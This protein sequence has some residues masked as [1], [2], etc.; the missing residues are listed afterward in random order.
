LIGWPLQASDRDDALET[1][2]ARIEGGLLPASTAG[3]VPAPPWNIHERMRHY[4]VPGVSIAVI[5][6]YTLEWV[7]SYGVLEAGGNAPVTDETLFQAASISKPVTAMGI[8][9][10]AQEGRLKLDGEAN[11]YLSMWRIPENQFTVQQKV[12]PGHLLTHTAGM[13][14]W[15]Y[16]GYFFDQPLPTLTQ[17]LDGQRPPANSA[18]IRV[19]RV[20]GT[21]FVYSNG[22][23]LV[24]QQMAMDVTGMPFDT[25][26]KSTV[27]DRLEMTRT[28]FA[29][30]LPRGLETNAARGHL[31]SGAMIRGGWK[32]QP[33]LASSGMWTTASDLARFVIEIQR[34]YLGQSRRV[35]SA[36]MTRLMLTPF[37]PSYGLGLELAS[38]GSLFYHSGAN[39]GYRN[40]MLGYPHTGDGAVILTNADSGVELRQEI[41]RA[42]ATEY[43][44]AHFR[45]PGF[46][47]GAPALAD[48]TPVLN[49]ASSKPEAAPGTIVSIYGPDLNGVTEVLFQGQKAAI[50]AA[51]TEQ[52]NAI[53]P[54]GVAP[55]L[56]LL[57]VRRGGLTGR[58]RE[59]RISTSAPGLFSLNQ[60]GDGPGIIVH[61]DNFR[62]VSETEPAR[63]GEYVSILGTGLGVTGVEPTVTVGGVSARVTWSGPMPGFSGVDQ[64]NIQVPIDAPRAVS[65]PLQ[66]RAGNSTSNTVTIAID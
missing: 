42:I 15:G 57:Q 64:V 26:I 21:E 28:T 34:S 52:I 43:G 10:L 51:T 50:L 59:V 17:I 32:I 16:T 53:V 54:S 58:A 8:L 14:P 31:S 3:V 11:Q 33:E 23:F 29:Q 48:S 2:I 47:A 45:V 1:R 4:N 39:D 38:E 30:P 22:G 40:V 36:E 60:R 7:K 41:A 12:F 20:P 62:L 13:T 49:A 5:H 27:L 61:G 19:E 6:N 24:L 44:W 18:A 65:V 25:W 66:M 9:W 55:G 35:L 37:A 46:P 63:R 56:A